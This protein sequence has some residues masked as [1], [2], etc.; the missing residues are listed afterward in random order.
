M[1]SSVICFLSRITQGTSFAGIIQHDRIISCSRKKHKNLKGA[2]GIKLQRKS[3]SFLCGAIT[4]P[5]FCHSNHAR[6][7][8]SML[9]YT[10]AYP[11]ILEKVIPNQSN[12]NQDQSNPYQSNSNQSKG[13]TQY[14]T[15]LCVGLAPARPRRQSTKQIGR[16]CF[17]RFP[18]DAREC[19]VRALKL[20]PCLLP[21]QA[22][23]RAQRAVKMLLRANQKEETTTCCEWNF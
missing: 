6:A 15:I 21:Y 17:L 20:W 18:P 7:C 9:R 14:L 19:A 1:S 3:A 23:P 22:A 5:F 2:E 8:P 12:P 16:E 11:S 4:D 13:F 10:R